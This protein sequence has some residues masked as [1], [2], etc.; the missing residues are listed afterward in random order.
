M[1]EKIVGSVMVLGGGIAGVQAAL[2]L[3]DSGY[4][5]HLVERTASV[6]GI[7]SQLDKTF[8]TNDCSMCIMAPKLVEVGRHPNVQLLTLSEVTGITGSA[9]NFT[10]SVDVHPRYVDVAR[11][12]AC[13]LCAEKCPKKVPDAYEEGLVNRKA[14]YVKLAQAV[15]LKYAIDAEHCLYLTK[16]RCGNCAKVCPAG[17][18]N[19]KDKKKTRR[20]NVGAVVM[21][22]GT[23]P[24]SPADFDTF[25]YKKFPN[26]VTA[27]EFERILS[28]SGPYGG[29]LVRPADRVEPKKIAWLQCVGSRD[30]NHAKNGYCSS[31]CCTYAI[32]E[33]ML[34]K[35]HSHH[36][37]DTAIFYID[38]RTNGKDFERFYNRARTETGVRFVKSKMLEV[39]PPGAEGQHIL[40]YVD[41][42]GR[43]V[44]EPFDIVVLSVG[45][46]VTPQGRKL[47]ADLGVAVNGYGFAETGSF[48]PVSTSVPG[49]FVCGAFAGPK[50]IPQSVM[51]ASAAAGMAGGVLAASRNS[52]VKEPPVYQERDIRGEPPRIGVFLCRCGTNIA[53]VVDIPALTEYAKTLPNVLYAEENMFSCSQATQDKISE[54]IREKG[55]NRVVV[56]AC[57]PKT[58]DPLFM[59]TL[60]AAGINKYLFELVNIRNHCSWVHKD[61]PAEATQK[62]MDLVKMSVAKAAL[63]MPLTE[64]VL[65]VNHDALVIGGG[66]AGLVAAK[67]LSSQ[68]FRAV[69][70]EREPELGGNARRVHETWR[71]EDVQAY[72]VGLI[73]EAGRDEN[74]RVIKNA[75]IK[76][77]EGFVGNFRTTVSSGADLFTIEH[78]VTVIACGASEHKP[79]G[80]LY[81]KSSRVLTGLSLSRRLASARSEVAGAR[82]VAFLQ[83][84]GSRIPERPYCS[85]LCCSQSIRNALTL[86]KKNPKMDVTILYRDMRPYGLR[87]DVYRE[88]RLK[89]IRFIRYDA[90]QALDVEE[91]GGGVTVT[92]T[93]T[94]L[95]RRMKRFTNYLVLASAIVSARDNPLAQLYKVP[96]NEDGFFAE[97]HVKLRPVDFATDG[98]F[99]CGLAHSP[100]PLDEAV[101]QAQAAAARAA[102]V[103]SR[104]RIKVPGTVARVA[105]EKCSA[106]GVCVSVCPYSAPRFDEKSG[107]AAIEATLCKGCGLC[108]A[109][110]RSG[111][112]ALAGFD[113]NQ[114]LAMIQEM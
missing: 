88:A 20:L 73:A 57:S 68:G 105:Q 94:V 25:G 41:R 11:C 19:Y 67:S 56:A 97:A 70:L 83:C 37:L 103:L 52:M 89:G 30:V 7:M 81:G 17:A 99:V 28:A 106:C 3:A 5:V 65:T 91:A 87:E 43:T 14:I 77:V 92:F 66:V 35:E 22:Q 15:P 79:E 4:F 108:T 82:S 38:I 76:G 72:L 96:Q 42:S 98:V 8:P 39:L 60:A 32:K 49:I 112:I 23:T 101:C 31:V 114:I 55:L 75:R 51:D 36:P 46:A 110:C 10:V 2:D 34:A 13:G 6:G 61:Q 84:V 85:K 95:K 74:I 44:R 93:E 113:T 26:V 80:Y 16:G 100:K 107:K 104:D 29:H 47:A 9:G 69:V 18:V 71:G 59:E 33:A 12:I 102:V 48:A 45:L 53:G 109:S 27:I 54:L 40:S 63:L 111:A 90:D 24:F 1:G 62:A 58:H 86:K 78:G 50:D 21:A 64:P